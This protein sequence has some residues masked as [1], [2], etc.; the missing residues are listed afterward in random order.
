[1]EVVSVVDGEGWTVR[2]ASVCGCRR[3]RRWAVE[4]GQ[5]WSINH[6][7]QP[8]LP[9]PPPPAA[10]TAPP[11]PPPLPPSIATTA[12]TTGD[13]YLSP[14]ISKEPNQ[15][16]PLLRHHYRCPLR[17]PP[18][19]RRTSHPSL[20]LSPMRLIDDDVVRGDAVDGFG[21]RRATEVE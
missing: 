18:P 14:F 16:P 11:P 3:S 12:T 13:S 5:R 9:H 15:P 21:H 1:M 6:I 2:C 17:P 19:L 20:F 10:T 8:H 7:P 4:V